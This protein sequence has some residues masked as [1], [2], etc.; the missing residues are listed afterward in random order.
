MKAMTDRLS[1]ERLRHPSELAAI[2]SEV[3]QLAS[4]MSPRSPFA[5]SRWLALW[6][7]HYRESRT[8]VLDQFF[9][10]AIR[11]ERGELIAIAPL[12]LTERP[13]RGP[14]RSRQLYFFGSD[15]SITELRGVICAP[16]HEGPAI[17][18]LVA[19]LNEHCRDW[20]WFNWN[21][22]RIDTDAHRALIALKNFESWD[23]TTDHV[24]ILPETWD[25][26]RGSRS[27]NIK[28][29]L[30]KCYNSLKRDGHAFEFRV[31]SEPAELGAA[32]QRFFDLHG[33]R[34]NAE[35]RV[36]H[37]NVF[38]ELRPRQLLLD[39]AA[40]P[41]DALAVRV[42]QLVIAGEVIASRVG[43]VLGDE[44]YL[45]FSGYEPSWGAYSVMTT[46]VAEAIKWAIEQHF[47]LVNLSPGTDVSKTRWGGTAMTT[48]NGQLMSPTRRAR[49]KFGVL[50][51]LNRHI[52]PGTLLGK[53]LLR[54]RRV[55]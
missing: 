27:R 50:S 42:F 44:L 12:I 16:E 5:T 31:V 52:V 28:E 55:G 2:A 17:R 9:V 40:H 24:L 54:A 38:A 35:T 30:R 3:D 53:L 11:N 13:G 15:K 1:V 18:A 20:D 7:E 47:R 14:L 34:A 36:T 39:L 10:H 49:L 32:L 45:Y 51:Q 25:L 26:F 6:W 21:G 22:V 8:W 33:M 4:Q 23:E 48:A 19:A 41:T 37:H 43:F 29:S 46:T